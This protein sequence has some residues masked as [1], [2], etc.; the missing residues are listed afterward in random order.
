VGCDGVAVGQGER[1]EGRRREGKERKGKERRGKEMQ[2]R[3][4]KCRREGE[5]VPKRSRGR[6]EEK[7]RWRRR[8]TQAAPRKIRGI[9]RLA[10]FASALAAVRGRQRHMQH[11]CVYH[12]APISAI[13]AAIQ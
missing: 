13:H 3:R 1:E 6:A 4:G 8:E 10:W 5:A 2:I 11:P 9:Y 7:Q 12:R